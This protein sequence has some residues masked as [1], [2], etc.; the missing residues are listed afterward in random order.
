M[1]SLFTRWWKRQIRDTRESK[2]QD[3]CMLEHR[4]NQPLFAASVAALP[5]PQPDSNSHSPDACS[6]CRIRVRFP[7]Y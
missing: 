4:K 2:G 6:G 3:Q 1:K 5:E 7:T